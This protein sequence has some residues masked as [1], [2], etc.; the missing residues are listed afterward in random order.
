MVQVLGLD[1]YPELMNLLPIQKRKEM[2]MKIL[3]AITVKNTTVDSLEDVKKLLTF[4]GP[5]VHD[6]EGYAEDI[7][8]EV[9]L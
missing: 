6:L 1:S 9:G 4:I 5:L 3:E 8:E 7:E 2:A